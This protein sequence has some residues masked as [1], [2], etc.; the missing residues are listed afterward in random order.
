MPYREQIPIDRGIDNSL[1]MMMEGYLYITN[2][3]RRFGRDMFETRLLGA[4]KAVC[5]AGEEA[6]K[7]FYDETKIMRKGAAPKRVRQTL[8]GEKA[9][10][11]MDDVNHKHRKALF[12]SLM[13][14]DRLQ[15]I[16]DIFKEEWSSA[17]EQWE[18][19]EQIV[20]YSEVT[21]VLTAA[22]CRWAGVFLPE[23]DLNLRA[24]QLEAMFDAA[25]AVGPRHWKGR[26][27][28]NALEQWL[29]NMIEEFRSGKL[30]IPEET[31][32]H[33]IAWYRDTNGNVLDSQVAAV[34]VLNIL[35]PTVA[36]AVYI[37]FTAL[38]VFEHPS[39]KIKLKQENGETYYEMFVQEV[40]R[41]YP[42]FP[43]AAARARKDF[44][45]KGHDFKKGNLVLLDIYGTN[46]HP[47]LWEKPNQFY[48]EHFQDRENNPFDFIP[49][50]GGEYKL[51]HRCPGE[52][53]TIEVMKASLDML[54]NHMEYEVP[55]QDLDYSM[56]RMPSLPKSRI[57][58]KRIKKI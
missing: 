11:T 40:R 27:G 28:R 20:L 8:F 22:V 34:E 33:Q 26:Q 57:I 24:S 1:S 38:A 55:E 54:M 29:K 31:A 5:I 3:R 2:R 21:K 39:E 56:S 32:M 15:E 48:P 6:A 42:F 19:K 52:W 50:G 46:H 49:Q 53:L 36:I 9:I 35:R 16:V 44:L 12:M 43:F 18:S 41:Y 7:L 30:E 14:E 37:V 4:Q 23:N 58:M 25:A 51:G 17:I 47:D 13:T 10:Q 45:W